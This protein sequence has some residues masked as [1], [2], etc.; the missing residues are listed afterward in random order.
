[1]RRHR[2]HQSWYR[3]FVLGVP[4]G[5]GPQK[6]ATTAHGNMLRAEDAASGSNFLTGEIHQIAELRIAEGGTVEPFRCRRN[7]LSSQPM[8]FNLIA[9]MQS[10]PWLAAE[11]VQSVTGRDVEIESDGVRLEDSPGH[12]DDATGLDASIRY[13]TDDGRRGVL[14][15]ETKLT[16]QFSPKVYSLDSKPAY[17]RYSQASSGPFDQV[18]LELLTDRRWNQLWRNQM[19]CAAIADHEERELAEQLVVFPDDAGVT[20]SLVAEY[21]SLLRRSDAVVARTLNEVVADVEQAAHGDASPWLERFRVRYIDLDLSQQLYEAWCA[22]R[23][24]FG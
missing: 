23:L 12:L 8:C 13:R 6:D 5:T 20:A 1:M 3:A 2:F 22:G 10:R 9:P 7:M 18:R 14:G 17:R 19:L 16:E 21:A 11:L 4:P 15:I 24:P